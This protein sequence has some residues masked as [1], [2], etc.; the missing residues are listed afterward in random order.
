VLVL[1]NKGATED[2]PWRSFAA[3]PDPVDVSSQ[4]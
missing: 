4:V 1:A 2:A 3:R